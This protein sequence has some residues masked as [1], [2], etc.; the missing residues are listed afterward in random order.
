[1]LALSGPAN[2]VLLIKDRVKDRS[3]DNCLLYN[4]V[5]KIE[6]RVF[7]EIPI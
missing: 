1:M 4:F 6:F 2:I 5:D 7:I 3:V